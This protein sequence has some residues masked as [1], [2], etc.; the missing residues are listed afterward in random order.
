MRCMNK[1]KVLFLNDELVGGGA[2]KVL[3]NLVNHMDPG[4]FCITVLT[5][6]HTP[7]ERYLAPHIRYKAIHRRGSPL[8]DLWLRLGIRMG[9]AYPL[10]IRE[11]YDVEIA[12]LE[13]F[14]TKLLARST[15]KASLKLA[16]V[17]CDL[18]KKHLRPSYFSSYRCFDRVIC[19]SRSVQ[20]RY[21]RLTGRTADVLKNV[22][23]EQEMLEKAKEFQPKSYG[24]FTFAAAGRLSP[25]KGFDR[26]ISAARRLESEGFSFTLWLLGDGRSRPDL[27]AAAGDNVIFLGFQENP[28]PYMAAVD[29]IVLPSRTEGSSTVAAE[30]MIL[31]KPIVA[32]DCPGMADLLAGCGLLTENSEA[33]IYDGMK[34]L[35]TDPTLREH[36]AAAAK[37]RGRRF[38]KEESVRQVEDYLLQALEEKRGSPWKFT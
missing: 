14:P 33:G 10:V 37:E 3:R 12:F 32:T 7:P 15:N 11:K 29:A 26:L 27:E 21:S 9:W 22:V 2:E 24:N 28:Y 25:E 18:E 1:I 8:L 35:L 38:S 34:R 16:W 23:D 30:A 13:C 31:G 17:H 36:L 6:R 19:V 5:L 20:E 4:K